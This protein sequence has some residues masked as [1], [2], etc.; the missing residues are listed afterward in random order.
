MGGGGKK[1]DAYRRNGTQEVILKGLHGKVGFAMQRV[2]E[3][4]TG[5]R[6]TY[7]TL[8]GQFAQHYMTAGLQE[9][10]AYYSNRM[11]D[12]EVAGLV[13]RVSGA[14]VLSDQRIEQRVVDTAVTIS[15]ALAAAAV[16]EA[17]EVPVAVPK[18][19]PQ[20]DVYAPGTAEILLFDDGIGVKAQ[21]PTRQRRE[22]TPATA[23]PD[24]NGAKRII[25]DVVMLERSD[26]QYQYWCEGIDHHG[27]PLISLEACVRQAL[28][29]EY[30]DHVEPLNSVAISD[31]ASTI[32]KTLEAIFGAPPV[33][34]L[35]WYHLCK[36]NR[37]LLSMIARNKAEKEQHLDVMLAA[38]WAGDTE[39][40]LRYLNTEVVA[41][42]AAKHAELIGYLEKHQHEI[43]DYG[44]RQAAGKTIGSG[45]MEKGVDQVVG[46]RQKK[47]AM[48]W[49]A[50]GS[51]ALAILKVVELNGQWNDFWFP[52][53]QPDEAAA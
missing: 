29:T 4:A 49:S 21:K 37:E 19:N 40:A 32:R 5:E 9:L 47:K 24:E 2:V 1:N 44:A 36:K 15:E 39:Q 35:D 26:G 51:K 20:V 10:A 7:F 3:K 31:G 25:T 12:E 13:E 43:I 17:E 38:L 8:T 6:G 34:I 45:R 52:S 48:S 28:Q 18:A 50:K 30:G 53:E 42:N 11:S 14:N 23:L 16:I 41:R 27:D 33:I 22:A 46:Q